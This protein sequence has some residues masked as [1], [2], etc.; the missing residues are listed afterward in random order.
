MVETLPEMQD[1]EDVPSVISE[2]LCCTGQA[3]HTEPTLLRMCIVKLVDFRKIQGLDANVISDGNVHT[4]G[5]Y[6]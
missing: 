4:G 6:A 2:A 1:M 3:Q 5:N